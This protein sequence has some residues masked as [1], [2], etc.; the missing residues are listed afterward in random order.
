ME[1]TGQY[2][3]YE[4][5]RGLGGKLAIMPFNLLEFEVRRQIDKNTQNR[6]KDVETIP[7]EV[8]LCEY[9]L[10]DSIKGY[11]SVTSNV[12]EHNGLASTNTDGYSESFITPTQ[13]KEVIA[14]KQAEIKSIIKDYLTGV[15]VNEEHILFCGGVHVSKQQIDFI[16]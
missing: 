9:S 10:I 14:S 15:I 3:T 11:A 4:E 5:Y 1:F 2:L 13:I 7:Q 12:I 16:S 8:K 6:L